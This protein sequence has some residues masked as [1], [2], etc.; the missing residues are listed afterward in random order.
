MNV[1]TAELGLEPHFQSASLTEASDDSEP[2]TPGKPWGNYLMSSS[3]DSRRRKKRAQ[4]REEQI[5]HAPK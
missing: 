2:E 5:Q 3:P 1:H 4:Q